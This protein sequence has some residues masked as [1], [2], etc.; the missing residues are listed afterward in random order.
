MSGTHGVNFAMLTSSTSEAT[1]G[2]ERDTD[3]LHRDI[4]DKLAQGFCV[5]DGA[6]RLV[7]ANS[8]Y[9]E[10]YGI[11]AGVLRP[12]MSL[13]EIVD[14]RFRAGSG[15]EIPRES[16]MEWREQIATE[17]AATETII[18]LRN[19]KTIE[20]QHTP[21]PDGGWV[22]THQDISR[23]LDTEA[24]LREQTALLGTLL[25]A[26]GQAMLLVDARGAVQ[27][28]SEAAIGLLG[29]ERAHLLRRPSFRSVEPKPDGDDG[30]G[31]PAGLREVGGAP[32]RVFA[33]RGRVLEMTRQ[34][35]PCGSTLVT[36]T[37]VTDRQRRIE[38]LEREVRSLRSMLGGGL[39]DRAFARDVRQHGLS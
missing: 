37:D 14:L 2:P 7:Q 13:S 38:A 31:R 3:L 12:G 17:H 6:H 15:P 27:T 39:P 36:Y 11:E 19:G 34:P 33:F 22:S 10:I 18:R 4:L 1:A 9:S 5:F 24:C 16:Y 28:F 21:M 26:T 8:R 29:L 23:R 25:A 32:A 30:A 20:I 35:A